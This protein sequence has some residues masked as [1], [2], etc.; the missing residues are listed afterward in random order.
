M[1]CIVTSI[2]LPSSALH[3]IAVQCSA[4]YCEVLSCTVA[5]GRVVGHT[6]FVFWHPVTSSHLVSC[7]IA[8]HK[9]ACFVDVSGRKL[10]C[11]ELLQ[12]LCIALY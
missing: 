2:V 4:L 1:H 12:F 7:Y 8:C 10:L 5:P 6:C 9:Q 3:C 11:F